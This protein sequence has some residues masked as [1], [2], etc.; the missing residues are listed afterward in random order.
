[1]TEVDLD[2]FFLDPRLV[3]TSEPVCE[4]ALCHV[5][6]VDD[7][8]YPWLLL[9]PKRAGV[10]ELF[11]LEQHDRAAVMEEVST[12]ARVLKDVTHCQKINIA[13]IGNVVSQLHLHIMARFVGDPT[14]PLPTWPKSYSH[15]YDNSAREALIA[16][17]RERL[18]SAAS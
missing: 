7:A 4:L 17:L 1:M 18:K 8:R 10:S 16:V 2:E 11:D 3:A 14:W 9:I 12:A 15:Q 5:R 6:L 13:M